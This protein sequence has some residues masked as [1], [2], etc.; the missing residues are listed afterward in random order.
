M[1]THTFGM[2]RFRF[3]RDS[4]VRPQQK[5]FK[6]DWEVI[7]LS[8]QWFVLLRDVAQNLEWVYVRAGPEGWGR[9]VRSVA[10]L[11]EKR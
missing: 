5:S 7:Q 2:I 1:K 10:V 9:R 11:W 3:Q 4:L 8:Q 6:R